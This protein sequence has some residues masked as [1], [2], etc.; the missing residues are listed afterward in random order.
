MAP[1]LAVTVRTRSIV[2]R[3]TPVIRCTRCLASR[4][5]G[6]PACD[7]SIAQQLSALGVIVRPKSGQH[8][9]L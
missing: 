8:R 6:W 1:P 4:P 5:R 7:V 2:E 9:R 3:P